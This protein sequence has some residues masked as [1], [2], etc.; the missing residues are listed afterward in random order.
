MAKVRTKSLISPYLLLALIVVLAFLLRIAWLNSN[1]FFGFEQGRDMLKL[2]EILSGDLTLVGPKTDISGVF[3]GALSYYIPLVPFVVFGGNPMAIIISY[4]V[5]NSV[6]IV[7]L[8]LAVKELYNERTAWL[9]SIFY[10][11]SYSAI[12]YSRWLSNPNLIP[13]LVIFYFFFLVK[14]KN[15]WKWLALAAITWSVMVHLIVVVPLSLIIPTLIYLY[16]EKVD[17]NF[18]KAIMSLISIPIILSTY[19]LFEYKFDFRMT[20]SL[21]ADQGGAKFWLSGIGFLD[22][23]WNEM[24]GNIFPI[25]P[26]VAIIIFFAILVYSIY[27]T[28][29]VKRNIIALSFLFAVPILFFFISDAPLRHFMI[30]TPV[31]AS[32]VFAIV[33][34]QLWEKKKKFA[35][36]IATIIVIGNLYTAFIRLPESVANFIHHA[37]RTYLTDMTN[38]IDY[39]YADADGKEFTYDYYSM[40]YWRE[41]AWIYLFQWYG[42][43]KYGYAPQVDRTNVD[44]S[45][46]FYTFIEPNETA[47]IHQDNWY[48]EYKKD[49]ELIDTYNS[50]QLKVEKRRER[51][52]EDEE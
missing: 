15:D 31:F 10:A 3:H 26:R 4:I 17:L 42:K 21:L 25:L 27:I 43:G 29:N 5:V 23:F 1:F 37:Q 6:A 14:S 8:F 12:I 49:L 30:G 41:D 22:Q 7:F 32:I 45:E 52:L 20:K 36:T 35:V 28:K 46:V 19:A 38:L 18:K 51:I 9:S 48:G 39:A 11:V 40:P 16:T 33:V 47:K 50:G 24:V 44:R 2:R 34:N 13:A